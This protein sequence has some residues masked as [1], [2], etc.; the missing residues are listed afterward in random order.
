MFPSEKAWKL[1]S[2]SFPWQSLLAVA[3]SL[4]SFS[5]GMSWLL[6]TAGIVTEEPSIHQGRAQYLQAVKY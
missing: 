3:N 2:I 6:G 4:S 5:H 1:V